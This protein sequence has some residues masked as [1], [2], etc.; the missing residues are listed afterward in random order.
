MDTMQQKT[1]FDHERIVKE[2]IKSLEKFGSLS[3]NAL[4]KIVPANDKSLCRALDDGA[5]RGLLNFS[6]GKVSLV[7]DTNQRL[8]V[9][10]ECPECEGR[11]AVPTATS[12]LLKEKFLTACEGAPSLTYLFNQRPVTHDTAWLRALYMEL[13]GDLKD[14]KIAVLGDDDLTSLA[15]GLLAEN[16]EIAVF[17]VDPRLVRFIE[18]KAEELKLDN[19]TV[20]AYDC[21]EVVPESFRNRYDVAICDPSSSLFDVFL[22]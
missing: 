19:L 10:P 17:E 6:N 2:I 16:C 18:K 1:R 22:V 13:K 5:A 3:I 9:L 15:I 14:S 7:N 11:L 8:A 20:Y 12:V 21:R 4:I